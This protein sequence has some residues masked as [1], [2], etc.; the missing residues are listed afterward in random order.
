MTTPHKSHPS[1]KAAMGVAGHKASTIQVLS[2]PR[3]QNEHFPVLETIFERLSH[4]LS[5]TLHALTASGDVEVAFEGIETP[6]LDA[7]LQK[8]EAPSAIFGAFQIR[9]W[10]DGGVL[11]L[12]S[13]LV[14]PALE[15]ML[16][17]QLASVKT[18]TSESVPDAPYTLVEQHLIEKF[19]E[20][21]LSKIQESF[22][23]LSDVEWVLEHVGLSAK[24]L[25]MAHKKS[26]CLVGMFQVVIEGI[27]G[28]FQIV[29]PISTIQPIR[30]LL[31]EAFL[32]D[33]MGNDHLWVEHINREID[34]AHV[35]LD[36]ILDVFEMPL[37]A[38]LKWTKGF[39]FPLSVAPDSLVSAKCRGKTVFKAKMGR[40]KGNLALSVEDLLFHE[41]DKK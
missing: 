7:Y 31:T 39:S 28:H 22:A 15:L 1:R 5:T 27:V 24:S 23:S 41:R 35:T 12:D 11:M 29:L 34:K 38:L 3:T 8:P 9:E 21:I 37:G 4:E 40:S 13:V 10:E 6:H 30:H 25:P 14:R 33:K 17:G 36:V 19:F 16:G 18:R 32:G 20:I 2:S 26:P